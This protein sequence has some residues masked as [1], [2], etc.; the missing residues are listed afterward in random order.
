VLALC[1]EEQVTVHEEAFTV[2][3]LLEADEVFI[4]ATK[5]DVVPIIEV[6]EHQI[7]EGRPGAVTKKIIEAFRASILEAV[8]V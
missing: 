7:G 2:S 3:D 6:D 4:T 8:R 1:E 5:L